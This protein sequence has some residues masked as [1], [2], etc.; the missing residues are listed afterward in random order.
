[1]ESNFRSLCYFV[2]AAEE[3]NFTRAAGKLYITQQSLSN[4]IK[5]LEA[6]YE[7][8][9]F[10]RKPNLRLTL[11]GERILKYAKSAI[12]QETALFND[13]KSQNSIGKIR[14][15]IGV[16]AARCKAFL[17]DIYYAYHR[18]YPR[19]I[20]SYMSYGYSAAD[21]MLRDGT[22]DLYF[23]VMSDVGRFGKQLSLLPDKLHFVISRD[24]LVRHLGITAHRFVAEHMNGISLRDTAQFPVVIPYPQSGLRAML[25]AQYDASGVCPDIVAEMVDSSVTFEMCS[26]GYCAAMFSKSTLFPMFMNNMTVPMYA[27]PVTGIPESS[28]L[29]IVSPDTEAPQYIT[30]YIE[31]AREVIVS[32]NERMDIRFNS[33]FS[34]VRY[35]D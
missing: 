18:L 24:L 17:P 6:Q 16:P 13:L 23:A 8:M 26:R 14:L 3:M 12:A 27:F 32:M 29:G 33:M 2:T 25:D 34:D 21:A 35:A 19:V 30:D 15:P 9:L 20:P 4:H 31:C 10:E 11:S 1:M 5:K 22:I 28:H 7:V